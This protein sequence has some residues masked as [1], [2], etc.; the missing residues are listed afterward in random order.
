MGAVTYRL[1]LVPVDTVTGA[2]S[3]VPCGRPMFGNSTVN[4]PSSGRNA[5]T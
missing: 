4:N 2:V 5:Q 1:A 3:L